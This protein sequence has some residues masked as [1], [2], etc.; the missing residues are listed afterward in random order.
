MRSACKRY[1][2]YTPQNPESPEVGVGQELQLRDRLKFVY[3]NSESD[4]KENRR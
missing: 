3:H 2:P 4:A 1:T